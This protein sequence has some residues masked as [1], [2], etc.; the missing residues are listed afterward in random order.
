[1]DYEKFRSLK[2]GDKVLIIGDMSNHCLLKGE[3]FECI[4]D[5]DYEYE[6]VPIGKNGE[7]YSN[8]YYCSDIDIC[9]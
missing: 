3:V 2:L 5:F 8:I 4:S 9:L 7:I 6:S 1:M